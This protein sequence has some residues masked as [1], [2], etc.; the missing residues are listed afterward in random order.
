MD[1]EDNIAG[2]S[3]TTSFLAVNSSVS[4][5][6]FCGGID[7]HRVTLEVTSTE[8]DSDYIEDNNP[9]FQTPRLLSG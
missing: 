2:D 1:C 6:L 7:F 3:T 9:T 4:H 5:D 8:V